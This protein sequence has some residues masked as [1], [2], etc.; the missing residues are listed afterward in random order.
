MKNLA[1]FLI[2][3]S[4]I[5]CTNQKDQAVENSINATRNENQSLER[6]A[7][8]I[9]I[10]NPIYNALLNGEEFSFEQVDRL[11]RE[12]IDKYKFT[13]YYTNLKHIGFKLISKKGLIEKGDRTQKE[14]YLHQQVEMARNF[15]N[16]S[17]FYLL[18]QSCEFIE[19]PKRLQ[20]GTDFFEKNKFEIENVTWP[21]EENKKKKISSLNR[22]YMLFHRFLSKE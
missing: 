6:T 16:F 17:E 20:L 2:L 13:D 12:N 21:N 7:G 1:L 22:S 19:M 14:F 11:Y 3:F 10:D 15:P 9:P 5:C 4:A 18:L 8:Q